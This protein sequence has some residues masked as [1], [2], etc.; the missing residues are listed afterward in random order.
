MNGD[1]PPTIEE[2]TILGSSIRRCKICLRDA[3]GVVRREVGICNC[4]VSRYSFDFLAERKTGFHA[5]VVPPIMHPLRNCGAKR[6]GWFRHVEY[7]QTEVYTTI[8][9]VYLDAEVTDGP[10]AHV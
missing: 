6:L 9:S 3:P 2:Y 7:V 1:G 4:P 8:L 5:R 10:C